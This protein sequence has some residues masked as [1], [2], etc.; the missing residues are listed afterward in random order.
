MTYYLLRDSNI[1]PKKELRKSLWVYVYL[2]SQTPISRGY[3][4]CIIGYFG[5]EKAIVLGYMACQVCTYAAQR[6]QYQILKD[7][8]PKSHSDHG[9]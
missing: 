5:V 7:L 9:L 6:A 2:E 3:F 8:G 1:L 4:S